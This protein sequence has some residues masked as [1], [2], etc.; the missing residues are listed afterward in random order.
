MTTIVL[1]DT[2]ELLFELKSSGT[3]TP[4]EIR[5]LIEMPNEFVILCRCVIEDDG[6]SK[7]IIPK[8]FDRLKIRNAYTSFEIIFEDRIVRLP[9][10][11]PIDFI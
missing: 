6:R 7:I 11:D 8:V 4:K 3:E 10:E 5:F 1:A 9:I 2:P